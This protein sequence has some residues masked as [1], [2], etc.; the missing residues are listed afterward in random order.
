MYIS[1]FWYLLV[2]SNKQNSNYMLIVVGEFNDQH[3]SQWSDENLEV[4]RVV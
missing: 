2:F 4:F 3:P 1:A